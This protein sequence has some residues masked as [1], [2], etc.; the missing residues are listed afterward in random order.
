MQVELNSVWLF[1][2]VGEI[3]DG[4]YRVLSHYPD[5][6][7]IVIFKLTD[8][9]NLQRPIAVS[10]AV[11]IK[12][13]EDGQVSP[14]D[15]LTPFYQLVSEETISEAHKNK[16][17]TRFQ[18][19]KELI[20]VPNFLLDI[21]LNPRCKH[22]VDHAKKQ[23]TYVQGLYRSLN[24]FWKYGQEL[25]ALLP[26]YKNSG[27]TGKSRIAGDVKRGSPIQVSTPGLIVPKGINTSEE[28]KVKF[29][30]AMKC[31][32][33]RGKAVIYSRVY[34][35]MLTE[36]YADELISADIEQRDVCVPSYRAFIY[37]V[38][39]LIP[40]QEII[41]KQ[42]SLGYFD[43]N[44]RGLSGSSTD[45][46][47]VP[48]SCYELDATVLDVHVVSE[49]RRNHVLGRP[50]LY[51]IIDK[52]SRMIV[53]IHVSM[54]FAS[55]RAG[56]QALVNCAS[57]KKEYC[58]QFGIKIEDKDWPCN[59]IPQRLL[60]DRGEFICQNAEDLAVPLIGHLSIAPPSVFFK[61]VV[62]LCLKIK[63]H[64][65]RLLLVPYLG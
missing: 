4:T 45:H 9:S 53:G 43:R 44:L 34:D 57:S 24:L 60:C 19:I 31:Y 18:Q 12:A 35:Q 7:I 30:K 40:K 56:R 22:V 13:T 55:W 59:H 23:N 14:S 32:G 1:E 65:L 15:Y 47:E 2:D 28:D 62:T 27:G 51:L 17:N 21:S 54:E 58:A 36:F 6:S 50:T 26:A 11:F 16:R 39:R 61:I 46:T 41:R 20:T 3:Q 37:W 33:L 25:N 64:L 52:E 5:D 49:I 63:L 8:D 38:N 10:I 42:T 48:G 29:L